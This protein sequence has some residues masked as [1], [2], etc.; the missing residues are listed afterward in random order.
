MDNKSNEVNDKN[1]N[2]SYKKII[3]IFG[4]TLAIILA[5]AILF[6]VNISKDTSKVIK[7]SVK[8]IGD[9]YIILTDK[10]S[11]DEYLID[12]DDMDFDDKCEVGDE[13]SLTIDKIKNNKDPIEAEAKNVKIIEKAKKEEIVIEEEK[14]TNEV[15]TNSS[16]SDKVNGGISNNVIDN[17]VSG[18]N[19]VSS[20]RNYANNSY[21]ANSVGTEEDVVSYFNAVS[22]DIDR[23][24]SNKSLSA[25]AK[26]GFVNIVD[27]LFYGGSIKGKTFNELSTSAKLKTLRLGVAIDKKID[28]SFPGYKASLSS[29]YQNVK[30]LAVS[31]YLDKTAEICSKNEDACQSAKEG[32]ADLKNNFSITWSFIKDISGVGL[33][34]LKTW[35]EVWRTS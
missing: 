21:S 25:S 34:K 32:L 31:K 8:Y 35:Y 19:E 12:M 11:D 23:S 13:L 27:F 3:L 26:S 15:S 29:K 33:S 10:D 2:V 4:I 7:G 9:D 24:S 18:N 17:N 20:N 6:Y 1:Y 5:L 28:N 22:T 30:S 16:D 14:P